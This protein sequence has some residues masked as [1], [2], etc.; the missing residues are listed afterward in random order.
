MFPNPRV[1][2][3]RSYESRNG[4]REAAKIVLFLVVRPLRGGG[5]KGPATKE[6]GTF[7]NFVLFV[8]VEKL[9]ILC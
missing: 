2:R 5:D 4:V 3:N 8:A 7:K 6:K 1:R 9:N